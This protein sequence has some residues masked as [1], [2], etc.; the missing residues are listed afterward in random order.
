MWACWHFIFPNSFMTTFHLAVVIDI[1]FLLL[2]CFPNNLYFDKSHL[3]PRTYI[4]MFIY[5]HMCIGILSHLSVSDSPAHPFSYCS[6]QMGFELKRKYKNVK[7]TSIFWQLKWCDISWVFACPVIMVS[8]LQS[9]IWSHRY[10]QKLE[11]KQT[12]FR[13]ANPVNTD[14]FGLS[15]ANTLAGIKMTKSSYSISMDQYW[16]G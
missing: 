12:W 5:V 13:A 8:A 7:Y 10:S 14:D 9:I 11:W 15:V 6:S 3:S 4:C 1:L 2:L 16:L